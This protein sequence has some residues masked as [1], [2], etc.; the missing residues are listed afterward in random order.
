MNR[1][2]L[3][4]IKKRIGKWLKKYVHPLWIAGIIF[5]FCISYFWLFKD[6]PSAKDEWDRWDLSIKITLFAAAAYGL[7]ISALRLIKISQQYDLALKQDVNRH[8][9]DAV[10]WLGNKSDAVQLGAIYA[11]IRLFNEHERLR[12]DI[13]YVLVEHVRETSW[14]AIRQ[15]KRNEW[16]KDAMHAKRHNEEKDWPPEFLGSKRKTHLAWEVLFD[17][18]GMYEKLKESNKEMQPPYLR[19]MC[20]MHMRS[21]ENTFMPNA[22]LSWSNLFGSIFPGI[23]WRGAK[24][25]NCI[26]Q[27]ADLSG[28][29]MQGA[30]LRG[31]NLQETKL[32]NADLERAIISPW[33]LNLPNLKKAKNLKDG[34]PISLLVDKRQDYKEEGALYEYIWDYSKK[35]FVK[36]E[37]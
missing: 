22:I 9:T 27:H 23:D 5:A 15:D 35:E 1:K 13:F 31:A 37:P 29:K 14:E 19:N 17:K 24:L 3:K 36:N 33:H 21:A 25:R 10:G 18:D 26:L 7:C 30:D 28:A 6:E 4:Q 11:L 34:K 2:K 20:Y 32:K 16:K 12:K 8:F